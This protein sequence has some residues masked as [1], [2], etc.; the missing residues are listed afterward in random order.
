MN[1]NCKFIAEIRNVQN[2]MLKKMLVSEKE[3][4]QWSLKRRKFETKNYRAL[5]KY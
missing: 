2:R 4:R 3:T 1:M 5:L